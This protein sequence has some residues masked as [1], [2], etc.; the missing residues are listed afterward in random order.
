MGQQSTPMI[1]LGNKDDL[2]E[3]EVTEEELQKAAKELGMKCCFVV[4][5]KTGKKVDKAFNEMA[6]LAYGEQDTSICGLPVIDLSP[7]EVERRPG[8]CC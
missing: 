3:K 2:K 4:S 1:L 6:E 7:P 8:L 5:A